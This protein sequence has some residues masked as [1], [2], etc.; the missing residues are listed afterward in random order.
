MELQRPFRLITPSLDGDVLAVLAR[1][2]AEFTPPQVHGMVGR[3]SVD[4]VRRALIRLAEQGIVEHRRA[5]N[6]VLYQLNRAHLAAPAVITLASLRDEL[7]SRLRA[8]IDAW[9]VRC[10]YAALF[11]SAARGE[12]RPDSDIDLFVV[13]PKRIVADDER[14]REQLIALS[15]DVAEWTGNDVRILEYS[16][17]EVGREAAAARR[18][19]R[20]HPD[21][22]HST[23]RRAAI[24]PATG[25]A[26]EVMA[27]QPKTRRCAAAM[28]VDERLRQ[29]EAEANFF[30][31]VRPLD[32]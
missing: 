16:T 26:K 14:W 19:A 17:D 28:P 5:G 11:G 22:R 15:H 10:E 7:V 30:A 29:L 32:D 25:P 2:D 18:C 9:Q 21:T 6:A 4:G 27:N 24:P 12:M 8:E 23:G 13:R 3:H 20:R 1:A 31:S